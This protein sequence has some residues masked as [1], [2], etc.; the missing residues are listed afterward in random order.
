[1][2]NGV[3]LGLSGQ[4][5]CHADNIADAEHRRRGRVSQ[6]AVHQ[7]RPFALLRQ[8]ERQ[9]HADRGLTFA[10]DRTGNQKHLSIQLAHLLFHADAQQID[11]IGKAKSAALTRQYGIGVCQLRLL[12]F[13]ARTLLKPAHLRE[14]PDAR[15]V[16]Q[17]LQLILI[18]N[19]CTGGHHE[20]GY[21]QPYQH[22]KHHALF[23][24]RLVAERVHRRIRHAA[25]IQQV[26]DR[27][28]D[29]KFRHL[30]IAF[31]HG[32]QDV[33]SQ[34]WIGVL[35]RKRKDIGVFMHARADRGHG[36][37]AQ[38]FRDHV[39]QRAAG[40]DIREGLRHL[41]RCGGVV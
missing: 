18:V 9:I 27:G 32:V 7:Q 38:P 10:G 39:A 25:L 13:S 24:R 2:Q 22:A 37:N 20:Y 12:P 11:S 16:H 15:Q 31:D 30:R 34:L 4:V 23:H 21:R 17:P 8:R 36:G 29:D 33:V 1:M 5:F 40:K 28:A 6:I 41:L 35:H 14:C 19:G 26:H 3:R